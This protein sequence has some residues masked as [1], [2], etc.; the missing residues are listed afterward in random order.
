MDDFK[1]WEFIL[2]FLGKL[3]WSG[4]LGSGVLCLIYVLFPNLFLGIQETAN[5][6]EIIALLG[7]LLGTGLNGLL[8]SLVKL[9]AQNSSDPLKNFRKNEKLVTQ[10]LQILDQSVISGYLTSDEAKKAGKNLILE[11]IGDSNSTLKLPAE[12]DKDEENK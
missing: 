12:I 10:K 11:L 3:G 6:F 7:G 8:G 9:I 1:G 4:F 2:R 5:S